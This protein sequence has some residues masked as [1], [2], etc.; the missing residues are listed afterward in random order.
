MDKPELSLSSCCCS[1]RHQ[2]GYAMIVEMVELGFKKVEL[3]HGI[4]I[5]LVPG[6]LKA[7]QE[8]LVRVSSVHNFCPLPPGV[9]AAAPNLYQPTG[10]DK[11]ERD[12]WLKQT[13]KTI[14]FAVK[15]EAPV[16]VL[17]GGSVRFFWMNPATRLE[18]AVRAKLVQ[19]EE[20]MD[21]AALALLSARTLEKV[22][23]QSVVYRANLK[24]SLLEIIPYAKERGI[25]LALENREDPCELPLDGDFGTLLAEIGAEDTLGYWHDTGHAQ[26]K[27]AA[28]IT[29]Q[30]TL[31]ETNRL[32]HF[33]WHLHDVSV[34]GRDHQPIGTGL[35]DWNVLKPFMRKDQVLVIELS[36]RLTPEQVLQSKQYMENLLVG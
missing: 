3:S 18:K 31:L 30:E 35:V 16:V 4:R 34:E 17:H 1:Q 19:D 20:A 8:K 23:K 6:V 32:R 5:S 2:E 27:Q 26:L 28:E 33:G 13:Q 29:R 36:P 24:A 7:L 12:F 9:F 10:K 22:R 21:G 15:V 25:K 14:D 11:R